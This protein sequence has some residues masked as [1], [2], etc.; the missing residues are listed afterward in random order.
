MIALS[1]RCYEITNCQWRQFHHD[2]MMTITWLRSTCSEEDEKDGLASSANIWHTAPS[3]GGIAL[4]KI[5]YAEI[6]QAFMASARGLH[7]PSLYFWAY[8]NINFLCKAE[9]DVRKG[10]C[11]NINSM[12]RGNQEMIKS[13]KNLIPKVMETLQNLQLISLCR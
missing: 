6:N 4:T 8:F 10:L 1:T 13:N 9:A 11:M 2:S 7:N 12:S 3:N 5:G